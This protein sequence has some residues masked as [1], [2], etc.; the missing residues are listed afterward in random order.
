MNEE[1]LLAEAMGYAARQHA[2]QTRN[3]G[4][5]YIYHPLHIAALVK[6]QGYPIP[7]QLVAIL[8]D[9]L[10]DTDATREDLL[11]FGEDVTEA[12]ELLSRPAGA[13]EAEY[14]RGILANPM[15]AVVKNADKIDN[16]CETGFPGP[17]GAVRTA[18]QRRWEENYIHKA[19]IYYQ[20][21]FSPALDAA[22]DLAREEVSHD[23]IRSRSGCIAE[24]LLD[25]M[26][27]YGER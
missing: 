2:G 21:K 17:A 24:T 16:L 18:R 27:L 11:Q 13:D 20:G 14:V 1:R 8:H 10:E 25:Q 26:G 4:T 12:V 9:V 7:Y 5:P 22:I 19:E 15:A 23:I 6:E 3:D